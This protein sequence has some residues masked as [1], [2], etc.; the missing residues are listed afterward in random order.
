[1]AAY[2]SACDRLREA[3][4]FWQRGDQ[5]S[6]DAQKL[7]DLSTAELLQA[8]TAEEAAASDL[9]S[10][11]QE[12]TTAY[13]IAAVAAQ[14]RLDAVEFFHK[15]ARWTVYAGSLSWVAMVWVAWFAFRAVIPIWGPAV[16]TAIIVVVAMTIVKRGAT[17]S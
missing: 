17:E 10:A 14:R 11:R 2:E 6:K 4:Q 1:V 9:L 13:Q 5:S 16:M 3:E 12:L 8:R 7:G 15:A